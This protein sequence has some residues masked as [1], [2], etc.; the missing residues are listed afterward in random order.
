MIGW[1]GSSR[2]PWAALRAGA[3]LAL[4]LLLAASGCTSMRSL[5]GRSVPPEGMGK[6]RVVMKDGYTYR[7]ARVRLGQDELVGTYYVVEERVGDGGE[8]TF[9]DAEREARLPLD[10]VSEVQARRWDVSKSLLI[11]AGATLFG[12]WLAGVLDQ[13]EEEEPEG[14]VKPH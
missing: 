14:N 3:A 5:P 11:G 10:N 2:G 4:A 1:I 13:G 8:V 6:V 7:F 12:I 9:V